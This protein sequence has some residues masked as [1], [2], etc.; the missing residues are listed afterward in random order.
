MKGRMLCVIFAAMLVLV[1]CGK[2]EDEQYLEKYTD[3]LASYMR[4]ANIKVY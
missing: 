1:G 3:T 4:S 2:N